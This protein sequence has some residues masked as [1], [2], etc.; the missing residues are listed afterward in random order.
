MSH[1]ESRDLILLRKAVDHMCDIVHD[2]ARGT[3]EALLTGF[4]DAFAPSS[5]V[6]GVGCDAVFRD[7]LEEGCVLFTVV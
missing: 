4:V 3:T 7:V 5:L 1:E 2:L 6:E